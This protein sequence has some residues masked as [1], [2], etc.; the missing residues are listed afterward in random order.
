VQGI[1][2]TE[3]VPYSS[4]LVPSHKMLD[5]LQTPTVANWQVLLCYGPDIAR[6]AGSPNILSARAQAPPYSQAL[7]PSSMPVRQP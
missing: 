6:K 7:H 1:A 5:S 3:Y 2:E 4:N